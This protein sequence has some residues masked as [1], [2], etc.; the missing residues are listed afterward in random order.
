MA[1]RRVRQGTGAALDF[2]F[3]H[4]RLIAFRTYSRD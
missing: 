2:L 3:F 1:S 4:H